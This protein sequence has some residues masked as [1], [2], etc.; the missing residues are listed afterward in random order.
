[1]LLEGLK[2]YQMNISLK[3]KKALVC[4]S[5][6]GIG[7]SCALELAKLGA[8]VTVLARN[9]AELLKVKDELDAISP[10]NH[11]ILVADFAQPDYLKSQMSS[12]LAKGNEVDILV[13]NTGGPPG[14]PIIEADYEAFQSALGLHLHCNHLLVQAVVPHMKKVGYGRII[15]IISTSVKIPIPGLGVSNTV[16]GAVANWSKTLSFE[17]GQFGITVNNVLPGFTETVRLESIINNKAAKTGQKT[18]QVVADMKSETPAGRFGQPE[19]VAALAA[20][21]STPAAAYINGTNIPVDGGR[22]G[23]L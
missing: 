11:Q 3:G 15:N 22:T 23:S 21:L 8:E 20:F 13:N 5:T 18:D 9:E 2:E 16:R 12:Y 4:G 7:K 14:G 6:Q 17:L 1:M 10:L 19:E